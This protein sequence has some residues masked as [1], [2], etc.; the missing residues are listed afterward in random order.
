[1]SI[2]SQPNPISSFEDFLARLDVPKTCELNKPIFK[3]M[4]LDTTDGKKDIL[5]A[6]DKKALKED[7][8]KIRWLYTLK[9]NTIN[10]AS[11]TDKTREYPEV[12]ILHIELSRPDRFKRTSQFINRAIPYPLVLIFTCVIEREQRLCL[13]LADK[14]INQADKEK[15]IIEDCIHTKWI[16]MSSVSAA[17]L[18]FFESLKVSSLPFT[19]F[20]AFYQALIKRV[21]AIKCAEHSGDFSIE[22]A[23]NPS[24]KMSNTLRLDKLRELE[25]LDSQRLE[26]SKK[27]KNIK[28]MGKK[29]ELNTQIKKINDKIANIKSSL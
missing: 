21:I 13:T 7:V 28:Q 14:R 26:I 11:Y 25:K 12:A 24:E 4:F 2:E 1:M 18:K 22:R 17:E 5:D 29:I 6:T 15:W 23:G 20:F 16:S 3:K 10:I 27:L 8:K 19:N 9:S